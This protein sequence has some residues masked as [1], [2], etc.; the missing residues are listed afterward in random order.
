M[1]KLTDAQRNKL[2]KGES[3][4]I[5]P[6]Q[7]AKDGLQYFTK[8]HSDKILRK[9]KKG[10]GHRV[11]LTKADFKAL[12]SKALEGTGF[13]DWLKRGWNKVKGK[14]VD[15][16]KEIKRKAKNT[17]QDL[18]NMVSKDAD[19]RNNTWAKV[20]MKAAN[21]V[22]KKLLDKTPLGNIPVVSG[23][24]ENQIDKGFKKAADK[25]GIE[26][27]GKKKKIDFK[28]KPKNVHNEKHDLEGESIMEDVSS[29]VKSKGQDYIKKTMPMIKE[30]ATAKAKEIGKKAVDRINPLKKRA[31]KK[32]SQAREYVS[33]RRE[34]LNDALE[35]TN[36]KKSLNKILEDL[37]NETS[38]GEG[39]RLDRSGRGMRL[40]GRSVLNTQLN[41]GNPNVDVNF[42]NFQSDFLLSNSQALVGAIPDQIF[43]GD[44][45]SNS[46]YNKKPMYDD[47]SST[48]PADILNPFVE[49]G[50][51]G[52][53]F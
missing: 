30:K 38:S 14:V 2:F 53:H 27:Y 44:M 23:L 20:G 3:I 18:K 45:M 47:V 4:T 32:V 40:H 21:Q 41:T 49:I 5:K 34:A 31:E 16:A 19:V 29:Y 28:M 9:L 52:F 25:A 6:S 12:R 46:I 22:S 13:R 15:K 39:L 10:K 51:H 42:P 50:D 11:K 33:D 17:V 26:G 43:Y 37:R 48:H 1:Y 24:I 36:M 35:A 8:G 7:I